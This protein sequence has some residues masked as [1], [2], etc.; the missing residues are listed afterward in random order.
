MPVYNEEDSIAEAVNEVRRVV[1][2]TVGKSELIVIND[3]SKDKTKSILESLSET[4]PRVIVFTQVNAGHGAALRQ[5]I[6]MARGKYMFLIDSDR[7]IPIESFSKLWPKA[8]EHDMVMGVRR[9]RHDPYTRILLTKVIRQTVKLFFGV[10]IRDANV[11]FKILKY[12]LWQKAGKHIPEGTLAPSL[13]LAIFA[14]Y[15]GY[16]VLPMEVPH[17]S[18]PSGISSIRHL[19]LLKFCLIAF[20]QLVNF[21]KSLKT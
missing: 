17:R 18:R 8:Q 9:I 3:G 11:P 15:A 16:K 1:L 7:Q 12:S 10:S 2:D 19:R 20:K 5:G 21:R 14:L 13:F 4:D 6:E